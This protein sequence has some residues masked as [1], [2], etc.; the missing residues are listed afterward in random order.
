SIDFEVD[1]GI[2]GN[3]VISA[4]PKDAE[5]TTDAR[6]LSGL[7]DALITA[8]EDATEVGSEGDEGYGVSDSDVPS[9]AEHPQNQYRTGFHPIVRVIAELWE[10][11]SAKSSK[12]AILFVDRW[13]HLPFRLTRRLGLFACAS[14]VVPV[15]LAAGA[16][17]ALPQGEL[18]LTGS[19]VEVVR[20]LRA[21]WNEFEL[22]QRDVILH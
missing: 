14:P 3:E 7:T 12:L 22:E 1:D 4:W 8:L 19:T 13:Q 18:F 11:L 20:L 21:R 2:D 10:R 5:A 17:I 6:L 16:L 9:V 15:A